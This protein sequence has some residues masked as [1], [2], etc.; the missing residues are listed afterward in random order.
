LIGS[1]PGYIGYGEGGQLTEAVHRKPYSV[2]L[3]DEVEKAHPEVMHV[4]LQLLEEGKVTD[5]IGRKVDFRN[6]TIVLT[7]NVGAGVIRKQT[8]LGFGAPSATEDHESNKQK[9]LEEAKQHFRPEL[10]NRLSDII[11]FKSLEK[12]DISTIIDLE[13]KKT[14][15]RLKEKGI[16]LV[17]NEQAKNFLI[18]KSYDV[19]YGAR[20]MRRAIEQY[21]EDP[22]AEELLK[23]TFK[24]GSSVVATIEQDCLIFEL[25]NSKTK[26]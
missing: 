9:V 1:P 8:T 24:I 2:I 16:S 18:E 7:S 25:K 6:T 19:V 17:L 13:I 22:L 21:I 10:L 23:N 14:S 20:P 26:M 4:L 3:F 15:E 11:V 5:S 12:K